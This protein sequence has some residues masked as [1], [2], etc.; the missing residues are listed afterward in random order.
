MTHYM[1][2]TS[3]LSLALS[4]ALS[5]SISHYFSVCVLV[6]MRFRVSV[7]VC[8]CLG[9]C[10]YF[11]VW[12]LVR[13]CSGI[14]VVH[15]HVHTCTVA[16]VFTCGHVLARDHVNGMCA[17]A[18]VA[19]TRKISQPFISLARN[20]FTLSPSPNRRCTGPPG[21]LPRHGACRHER[22]GDD[23]EQP[24]VVEKT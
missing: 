18:R 5:L 2:P 15:V 19:R 21:G 11:R 7:C 8:V 12:D 13:V 14:F 3:S 24:Q 22:H 20:L 6:C 23:R 16:C 9:V 1:P 4:L 10:A 17:R